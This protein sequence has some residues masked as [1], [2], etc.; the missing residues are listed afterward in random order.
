MPFKIHKIIRNTAEAFKRD[1][2]ETFACAGFDSVIGKSR[3]HGKGAEIPS[4]DERY[5]IRLNLSRAEAH[6]RD[7]LFPLQ[8]SV[9]VPRLS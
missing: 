9:P 4:R 7:L 2:T 8:R 1:S 6:L 3:P 5:I